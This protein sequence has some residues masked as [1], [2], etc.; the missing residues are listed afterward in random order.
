MVHKPS[1]A[2][3]QQSLLFSTNTVVLHVSKTEA[4]NMLA[5]ILIEI[6]N[7]IDQDFMSRLIW[8]CTY[9][10]DRY[11]DLPVVLVIV[12][13]GF[14][15]ISFEQQF[16]TNSNHTHFLEM[17][18]KCWTK[19]CDFTSPNS[20]KNYIKGN[21][22]DPLVV[23]AYYMTSQLQRLVSLVYNNVPTVQLLHT[24]RS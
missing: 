12:A 22:M 10:F 17:N 19:S 20:I 1:S 16:D 7:R 6:Q 24:N 21:P 11:D 14:S 13:K 8:Y 9:V 18:Y 4:I 3:S 23:L 5:P 2:H 15:S